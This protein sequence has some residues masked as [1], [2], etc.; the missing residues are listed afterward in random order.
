[1]QGGGEQLE[2]VKVQDIVSKYFCKA[3][4][5]SF[6]LTSLFEILMQKCL[7]LLFVL[8][9]SKLMVLTEKGLGEAIQEFIEK[10]EKDAIPELI[11][12][13]IGKIQVHKKFTKY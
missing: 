3:D 8:K 11:N 10:D 12:F 7:T 4:E 2:Y 9:K 13:Q 1:M 6:N 5:V